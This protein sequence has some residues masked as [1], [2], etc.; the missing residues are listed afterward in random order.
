V[1]RAT[2]ESHLQMGSVGTSLQYW[3]ITSSL[4]AVLTMSHLLAKRITGSGSP[5]GS[6]TFCVGAKRA[7]RAP[8]GQP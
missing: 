4:G 7:T 3:S 5:L 2:R 8:G 1:S 6:R